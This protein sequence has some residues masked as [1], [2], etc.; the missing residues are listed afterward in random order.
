[1]CACALGGLYKN[2]SPWHCIN[3][4]CFMFGSLLL[5]IV[6]WFMELITGY[7]AFHLWLSDLNT[8]CIVHQ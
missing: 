5:K 7:S 1:M 8:V 4:R 3:T 6:G 2:K